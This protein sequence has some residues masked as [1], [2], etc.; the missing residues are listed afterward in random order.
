MCANFNVTGK[1]IPPEIQQGLIDG[2]IKQNADGS[3]SSVKPSIYM[4][5]QTAQAQENKEASLNDAANAAEKAQKT[6]EKI[7]HNKEEIK[8][9]PDEYQKAYYEAGTDE[10][11][12]RDVILK[13]YNDKKYFPEPEVVTKESNIFGNR[14]STKKEGGLEFSIESGKEPLVDDDGKPIKDNVEARFETV[15]GE[16][17]KQMDKQLADIDN[18]PNI[19]T[20]NARQKA[21]E[22]LVI[23]EALNSSLKPQVKELSDEIK[24]NTPTSNK[25]TYYQLALTQDE[26][27]A[28]NTRANEIRKEMKTLLEKPANELTAEDKAKLT[29]Y[30]TEFNA[31]FP[32]EEAIGENEHLWDLKNA[33]NPKVK[34]DAYKKLDALAKMNAI[35]EHIASEQKASGST[36]PTGELDAA[37]REKLAKAKMTE[38]ITHENEIIE[39]STKLTLT[40]DAAEQQ[41]IKKQI[42]KL[43]ENKNK[44]LEDIKKGRIADQAQAQVE[45]ESYKQNYNNTSVH[46]DKKSAKAA[47]KENPALNNTHLNKY[48]QNIIKENPSAY[49]DEAADGQGDFTDENG[50]SWKLNSDKYKAEMLRLS[51]S[52]RGYDDTSVDGD[53]YAST[54]EWVDFANAHA[55]KGEG[56]PATMGERKDAREMFEAAGIQV[57]KD[58]TYAYRGKEIG[59]AAL[60][61]AGAGALAGLGG[62]LLEAGKK[63][64][65]NGTAK[66]IAEGIASVAI[67]GVASTVVSGTA[68]GTVS[69][70]EMTTHESIVQ[71]YDPNTGKYVTIGHQVTETPVHW[72]KD[73]SLDYSQQVDIPYQENV[74]IP[75]KDEVPADYNGSVSDKFDWG[76]IAKGA[77]IGAAMG[78]G[79]KAIQYLF[80]KK[81]DKDYVNA[82]TAKDGIRTNTGYQKAE[83]KV[84][85]PVEQNPVEALTKQ[86]VEETHTEKVEI[87]QQQYKL[88]RGETISAVICGKYN[89]KYG[90][91]EYKAILKYVRETANGLKNGEIPT[92]DKYN[93]PEWIPGE[94]FGDDHDNIALDMDGGVRKTNYTTRRYNSR[95]AKNSGTYDKT[96]TTK[97][98]VTGSD[99]WDPNGKK[100]K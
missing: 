76:N 97:T 63:L 39:L 8:K 77:G 26:K 98:T 1:N 35:E 90:T 44:M 66:G 15:K 70:T 54:S 80:K 30:K 40:K 27:N 7:I 49:C 71:K 48:A 82:E 41:K 92:G 59:K 68:S 78:G 36:R 72:S 75:Y 25:N 87:P 23:N 96:T 37:Q 55:K 65:Y 43:D 38:S 5:Q 33:Q 88:Q 45:Y 60:K 11:K 47:E 100:R 16:F 42:S 95:D 57:S 67:N 12:Q 85:I 79:F 69:G 2:T 91:P 52:Q 14:N 46:W 10:A 9:L 21:K 73:V 51:N 74:D 18:N 28:V 99:I 3:Y 31:K 83:D 24:T 6:A 17:Q 84:E 61:G 34:E 53:Y 81:T 58:K 22:N 93:L 94:V 19:K 64:N 13:Y 56:R 20:E 32:E 4:E 86:V 89:V 29:Q 62:E 50:K